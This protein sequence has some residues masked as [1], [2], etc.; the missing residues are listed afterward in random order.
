MGVV[1]VLMAGLVMVISQAMGLEIFDAYTVKKVLPRL[2]IAAIGISLSWPIMQFVI[3]FFNDL[4]L[5]SNDIILFPFKSLDNLATG[6]I[7][8][9]SG[10]IIG[11]VGVGMVL[12]GVAGILSLLG[13]IILA[14]LIGI[15]VLSLR[16]IIILM[17]VL[18]APL[19]IA[20][21]ILPGTQKL[22]EFWKNTFLTALYMFP[23]ITAFIAA[24]KALSLVAASVPNSPQMHL[25]SVLVYFAPYFLLPFAFKLA[26]GLMATVFSISND[27]SRGA[28]DRLKKGRQNT[29]AGHVAA[30][31]AGKRWQGNP[32]ADRASRSLQTASLLG[33]AGFDPRRM[34]GRVQSA[35]S[36]RISALS[37]EGAEKST[38]VRS[39]LGNDDLLQASVHGAGTEADARSY[40][41]NLGQEGQF[42]EQNVASIRQAKRDMGKVAFEDFAAANIAGTGTGFAGGGPAE[43]FRTINRVAGGD[44]ARAARILNS[45]RGQAERA[46]RVDLYGA[47]FGTSAEMMEQM[48]QNNSADTAHHVNEV[49]TDE[50]LE[51]KSAGEIGT[52]RN[53]GLVN[54]SGSIVRR[55]ARVDARVVAA[56]A[57]GNAAEIQVAE[58]EQKRILAHTASLL[59]V[60]GSSSP[61][62]AQLVGGILGQI[63][64]GSTETVG[65]RIDALRGDAEFGQY[66]REYG[67]ARGEAA[68]GGRYTPPT[69]EG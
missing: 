41:R 53:N 20:A 19:A 57:G 18:L 24:G 48:Y 45:A 31:K 10:F 65:A 64:V 47:G 30:I 39:V 36:T 5:W 58:H 59:D 1:F 16:Q 55:I 51:S 7:F 49:M 8:A 2:L 46:K 62:N 6:S 14:L 27:K 69:P 29:V 32:V 33:Q 25:L 54:M 3:T 42:L 67:S 38:A 68:A 34:R 12:L 56:R 11:G 66:R 13:T 52:S 4:G 63:G 61:E 37:A 43:M 9:G 44:R 28:F 60:A 50:S 17:A 15:L 35:R 21:Y 26:G 23:I 22:W 40:L